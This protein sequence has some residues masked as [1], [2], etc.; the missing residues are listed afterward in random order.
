MTKGR[1]ERLAFSDDGRFPN[2]RLPVVIY[3]G[4]LDT[5]SADAFRAL[6]DS[7]Q[8]PSRWVDSIFDYHHYH[9]TAHEVLGISRGWASVALGGPEGETLRLKAGD[10]LVLPAGVA[11]RLGNASPDFEVVGAY[12]PGQD[13]DILKG[14]AGER[15][16]ALANIARVPL[17]ETDP[18]HGSDGTLPHVWSEV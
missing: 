15:E 7:N 5:A 4:A 2:S 16:K 17:P 10:A 6:F 11:H 14:E 1:I 12:P 18:V 3:H 8:W 9:S 13:W